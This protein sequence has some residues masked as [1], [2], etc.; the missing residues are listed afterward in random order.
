[1]NYEWK[2]ITKDKLYDEYHTQKNSTVDLSNKYGIATASVLKKMKKFGI[3]RRSR[4]EKFFGRDLSGVGFNF[5]R[6]IKKICKNNNSRSYRQNYWE[7][8]CKCGNIFHIQAWEIIKQ[9][10]IG[11]AHCSKTGNRNSQFNGYK[12]IRL[13]YWNRCKLN[14]EKSGKEFSI[15][16][17]YVWELFIQ[18]NKLC[19]ISG[20]PITINNGKKNQTASLDRIDSS[21][22]YIQGNVQWV[23]KDINKMKSN[24]NEQDFISFCHQISDYQRNK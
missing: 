23:H 1:M 8:E 19:K 6:V 21:K 24:F 17:E 13:S 22:G 2:N 18:Q 3:E 16:I 15:T 20:A 4:H 12:D 14:S 11:C 9:E 5:I 10:R 7:C